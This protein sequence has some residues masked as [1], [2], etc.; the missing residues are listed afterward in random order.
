MENSSNKDLG[1]LNYI[2]LKLRIRK[3]K[4]IRL[5]DKFEANSSNYFK[6]MILN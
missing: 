4:V 3:I 1:E 6:I 2:F 5:Y